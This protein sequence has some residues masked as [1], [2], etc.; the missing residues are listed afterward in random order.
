MRGWWGGGRE[1]GQHKH[2]SHCLRVNLKASNQLKSLV[3]I[4][5]TFSLHAINSYVRK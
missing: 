2:A 3:F 4:L 1:E 5:I